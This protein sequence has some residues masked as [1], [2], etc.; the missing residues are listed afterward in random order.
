[1]VASGSLVVIETRSN[2]CGSE[3]TYSVVKVEATGPTTLD[4]GP[5]IDPRS[6]AVGGGRAYW[7][8]GGQ[9]Q[10]ATVR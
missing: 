5:D 8:R 3:A 4:S 9:P 7:M 1:M 2:S 10:S 6:L